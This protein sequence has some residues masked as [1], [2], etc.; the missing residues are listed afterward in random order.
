MPNE[1]NKI[2]NSVPDSRS[3]LSQQKELASQFESPGAGRH[4]IWPRFNSAR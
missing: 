2:K 3:A 4:P 1:L